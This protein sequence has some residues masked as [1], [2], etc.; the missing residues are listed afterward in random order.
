MNQTITLYDMSCKIGNIVEGTQQPKLKLL[1][2][3]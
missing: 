1:K 2:V 3:H